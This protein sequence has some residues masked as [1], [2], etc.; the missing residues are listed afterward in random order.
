[1]ISIIQLNDLEIKKFLRIILSLQI[2]LCGIIFIDINIIPVPY[3]RDL[4][5][6]ICLLFVPGIIVLRILKMHNL[7]SVKTL[8]YS[9]GLSLTI[10]MFFG[11]F[12]NIFYPILGYVKPLSLLNLILNF[13]FITIIF[14]L[15][16]YYRDKNF[17]NPSFI[18]FS[19][20]SPNLLFIF[21]VPL[22]SIFGAYIMNTYHSNFFS[23]LLVVSIAIITLLMAYN[24]IPRAT[25]PIIIA[26]IAISLLYSGSLISNNL[27]GWDI[28]KEYYCAN[29]VI[30]N[31]IWNFMV[32]DDTNSMLSVT[33][34]APILSIMSN[35]DLTW[36]F[37]I[38][39]PFLFSAVP[40]ILYEIFKKQTNQK[41][42]L[43]S[44]LFFIFISTFFIEMLQLGKEQIG[45]FFMVLLLLLLIDD[46]LTKFNKS[47][48]LIIFGSSLIVSHYGI[49]YIYL[50]MFIIFVSLIVIFKFLSNKLGNVDFKYISNFNLF[51]DYKNISYS[52]TFILFLFV[53]AFSWYSYVSDSYL[54]FTITKIGGHV[55]NN[56][57]DFLD[58]GSIQGL[59]YISSASNSA[60]H[61][62]AKYIQLISQFFILVG[63]VFVFFK[64]EK[65]KFF[66]EYILFSFAAMIILLIGISIPFFASALNTSRLYQLMLIF[67]SP[68]CVIGGLKIFGVILSSVRLNIDISKVFSIFLIIFLLFNTGF[69]YEITGDQSQW[70]SINKDINNHYPIFNNEE[71]NGAQWLIGS[72]NE[73]HNRIYADQYN[74]VLFNRFKV[75][76]EGF[77][78]NINYLKERFYSYFGTSNII[79]QKM[80]VVNKTKNYDLS[81][82]GDNYANLNNYNNGNEIYN[83][84]GSQIYYD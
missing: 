80:Y 62:I 67:L 27:W 52:L 45:E 78:S 23:M 74:S 81:I 66:D 47:I 65:F 57:Y 51:E 30:N 75:T 3:L 37:K 1:M 73:P 46:K 84:G 83:N 15:M 54:L 71:I 43:F 24:K 32:P 13:S 77:P 21:L 53:V 76:A 58:P 64:R 20:L 36:I 60:L 34:L 12:I 50:L 48:L 18:N 38:V 28:Q 14:C 8:A 5:T 7:G 17:S 82:N 59:S 61:A 19:K 44:V 25:Y 26:L 33:I 69:V 79:N 2:A 39:F 56:I 72:T 55:F 40:V 9:I 10:I 68:F 31:S 22:L 6:F 16:A 29:L 42:A 49:S 63:F 70:I 41:I 35:L 11:L 4:I